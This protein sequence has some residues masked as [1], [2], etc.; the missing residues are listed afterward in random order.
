M[1]SFPTLSSQ[2]T[3]SSLDRQLA[4][5]IHMRSEISED[6]LRRDWYHAIHHNVQHW[7]GRRRFRPSETPSRSCWE[8]VKVNGGIYCE[9]LVKLSEHERPETAIWCHT[10]TDLICFTHDL[11]QRPH[12]IQGVPFEA[13]SLQG[14]LDNG[15][16]GPYLFHA[17]RHVYE[18][19]I[20]WIVMPTIGSSDLH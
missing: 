19:G 1:S 15:V 12:A 11:R 6:L 16:Q 20:S 3:V 9:G 17:S 18:F 13:S 2:P 5:H 14:F 10:A 4:A 7:K 8:Y